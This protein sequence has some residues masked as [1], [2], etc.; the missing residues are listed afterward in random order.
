MI[1]L[2]RGVDQR[3][4]ALE[5]RRDGASTF[6][7]RSPEVPDPGLIR[8]GIVNTNIGVRTTSRLT[9]PGI[10]GEAKMKAQSATG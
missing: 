1:R 6:G 2:I 7:S 4:F 10:F 9:E 3:N 5:R 8:M